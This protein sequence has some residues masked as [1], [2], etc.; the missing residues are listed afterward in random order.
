MQFHRKRQSAVVTLL[1]IAFESKS[2]IF[3]QAHTNSQIIRQI[4]PEKYL[5]QKLGY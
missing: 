2:E 1:E 3:I 4:K 5:V